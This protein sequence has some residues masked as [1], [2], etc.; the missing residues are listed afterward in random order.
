[1]LCLVT[2]VMLLYGSVDD[3][4]YRNIV[5][6]KE[7]AILGHIIEMENVFIPGFYVYGIVISLICA[8]PFNVLP[9]IVLFLPP[10]I[11]LFLSIIKNMGD[12]HIL[13]ACIILILVNFRSVIAPFTFN[14]HSIGFIIFLSVVLSIIKLHKSTYHRTKSAL[15][16]IL[17]LDLVSLNYLSYKATFW[18]LFFLLSFLIITY[19]KTYFSVA[20]GYD[21]ELRTFLRNIT[22]SGIVIVLFF[23]SFFYK[24]AIPSAM[25]FNEY[26]MGIDKIFSRFLIN[27]LDPLSYFDLYYAHPPILNY[28][29]YIRLIL[30]FLCIFMC[31]LLLI[32][33]II[34]HEYDLIFSNSYSLFLS[35][36][37]VGS[38]NLL[39]YNLLGLF[40][41]GI[42]TY[43]GFFAILYL[44]SINK[45]RNFLY[46]SI[47]LLLAL[48]ISYQVV[49]SEYDLSQ[50]D[51]NYFDFI[52]PS[53]VW[54]ESYHITPNSDIRTDVLTEGYYNLEC[55]SQK[56]FSIK[57][58]R[59]DDV[60]FITQKSDE[61]L[62][63]LGTIY[64][65]N[66]RLT[67]FN[68]ENFKTLKSFNIFNKEINSN[69][70]LNI[71]Y[72]SGDIAI[73]HFVGY[74]ADN[75]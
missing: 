25:L 49:V 28:I 13:N 66:Y 33:Y 34:H 54:C 23:N 46:T 63:T 11:M 12:N 8:I 19:F 22:L 5:P 67:Y 40:D 74:G 17:L 56:I 72:N 9:F 53:S 60:L 16:L 27:Q 62:P 26:V 52:R 6:I 20:T 58:L 65:I 48:D 7:Y 55:E 24:S 32:S 29:V 51:A 44:H 15:Y 57:T 21:L 73:C 75:Y 45:A 64:I 18:A 36:F 70:H 2:P 38:A 50:R 43:S 4:I 42:L 69:K 3:F 68:I 31:I 39:A 37:I 30:I 59:T 1:M 41:L 47:I 10:F 35:F 14:V 71:L 61:Y